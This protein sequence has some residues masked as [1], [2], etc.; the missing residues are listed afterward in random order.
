MTLHVHAARGRMV[1]AAILLVL[2]AGAVSLAA[3]Q[4][5][6]PAKVDLNT[7]TP[8]QLQQLPGIGEANAQKIIKG[9]PY[10]SVDDLAKTG[11][12]NV[13]VDKI[14]PM[15]AVKPTQSPQAPANKPATAGPSAAHPLNI[16]KA[17]A[18][19]LQELPGIGEANAQ[20]IIKGRPY[21]SVDD[22][23][24]AG[25][26][27]ATVDKIKPMAS[28]ETESTTVQTPP[29]SG[30]VWANPDSKIYHKE[31]DRWYGKTKEGQWM[32]EQDA[33]KQGYRESK[34]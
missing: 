27:K 14:R 26:P 6:A 12:P 23:V 5:T 16:N 15:V 28:V 32:T 3:P 21:K 17:S 30:M 1:V 7:A 33:K 31:G 13:T 29:K 20:K 8:E 10:T 11:I 18:D 19:Q 22:L 2:A 34:N 24:K 9:R 4:P 25:V